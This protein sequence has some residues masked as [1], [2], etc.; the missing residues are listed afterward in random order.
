MALNSRVKDTGEAMM[1]NQVRDGKL[2]EVQGLITGW[3]RKYTSPDD[4]EDFTSDAMLAV[5]EMEKSDYWNQENWRVAYRGVLI[6]RRRR[7]HERRRETFT[8]DSSTLEFLAHEYGG[9]RGRRNEPSVLPHEITALAANLPAD[10]ADIFH[11][12]AES[13]Y[14]GTADIRPDGAIRQT[15]LMKKTGLSRSAMSRRIA[16]IREALRPLAPLGVG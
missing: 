14:N 7:N 1:D 4:Y 11:L 15:W 16:Q 6:A 13:V 8:A 10:V 3:A 9:G 5:L 2:Q 12:I